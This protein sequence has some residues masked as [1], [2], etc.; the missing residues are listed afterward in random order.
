[1]AK[2]GQLNIK[3]PKKCMESLTTV[4]DGLPYQLS[5]RRRIGALNLVLPEWITAV[6]RIICLEKSGAVLELL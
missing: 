3:M 4:C 5:V 6:E 1:M 2:K